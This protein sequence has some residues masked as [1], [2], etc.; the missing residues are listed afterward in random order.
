[1]AVN[2]EHLIRSYDDSYGTKHR[3][4]LLMKDSDVLKAPTKIVILGDDD[5]SNEKSEGLLLARLLAT[6]LSRRSSRRN[7]SMTRQFR[8]FLNILRLFVGGNSVGK[9]DPRSVDFQNT[10]FLFRT[11]H[12]ETKHEWNS[13]DHPWASIGSRFAA[14]VIDPRST[15]QR[16]APGSD[17]GIDL[18]PFPEACSL[19]RQEVEQ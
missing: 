19:G 2:T 8:L 3:S 7:R 6:T 1:M 5:A 15:E 4:F 18:G 10:M 13:E 12:V 14:P 11:I 16:R 9:F 17:R